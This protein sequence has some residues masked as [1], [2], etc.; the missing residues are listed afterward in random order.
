MFAFLVN[1]LERQ[2]RLMEDLIHLGREEMTA[3]KDNDMDALARVTREQEQASRQLVIIEGERV[4][5]QHRLG[6]TLDLG[7]GLTLGDVLPYAG[8]E[9]RESLMGIADTLRRN[10][11][12]LQELNEINKLLIRQSLGYINRL[13]QAMVPTENLTYGSMGQVGTGAGGTS[14]IDRT[15]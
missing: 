10:Y 13:L 7:S 1:L 8:G 6:Q 14:L 4:E 11:A 3:L 15:V 12:Q 2:N 9:Y 5:V